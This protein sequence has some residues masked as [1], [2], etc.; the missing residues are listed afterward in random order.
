VAAAAPVRAAAPAARFDAPLAIAPL[1]TPLVVTGGFGEYRVGHFHAGFDFGT[2]KKV[3]KSV[4]APLP[5][6]VERVR[7]SGVGY[8]RSVYVRSTDGRLL[9]FGHLDAYA[10]PLAAWVDSIQRA[11]GQYEQDLWPPPGRFKVKVGQRIA[12]TGES[13]AGGP[14]M[15]F[16]IRRGDVA[17]HPERAG[18][19]VRDR[20][21]PSLASLTL[22]PLDPAS[23]VQ[24]SAAPFTRMLASRSSDTLRVL[25]R[26]R[27]VVGARDGVWSG[28]DRMVPWSTRIEWDDQWV[29][30]R[31]DSISWADEMNQSDY[32]YDAGRVVG[33]KGIVLWAPANWR[34]RFISSSAP[35]EQEAG[36]IVVREGD[37]PR[38]VRVIARD[39]T[40]NQVE[41][42]VVIVADRPLASLAVAPSGTVTALP[43]GFKR[44]QGKGG[45]IIEA[46]ESPGAGG[47][48]DAF[49]WDAP[50]TFD[51]APVWSRPFT[52]APASELIPV[53][54]LAW[55]GPATTP[56]VKS[57]AL[58]IWNA[59]VADTAHVGLYRRTSEDWD[60]VRMTRRADGR[61]WDAESSRLGDF[62]LFADTLAPRITPLIPPRKVV[63]G[64][65]PRWAF[66]A[67]IAESGSGLDARGSYFMVD[68]QRVPTEW[69]PEANA[70]RWRP[71]QRP[72]QGTHQVT[73]VVADRAGNSRV[74]SSTFVL[75]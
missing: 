29:E 48:T 15:H 10:P 38:T 1:D 22:E 66:E 56:L 57:F 32:V 21:P 17:F 26:V 70:L 54:S 14:H 30:C 19:K 60:F 53:R 24:G 33:D 41:R 64:A 20:Q 72:S 43:G 9:Q 4:R 34:P 5:G 65:Y 31:M 71:L 2:G 59:G 40:G 16:E 58:R 28:V 37:A 39:V 12:W 8:G 55:I 46:V 11:T 6:H 73:I 62:A 45:A 44:T 36:T 47:K 27:A 61:G 50:Q 51:R 23:S 18:L 75:D 35:R 25:G 3:G 74:R 52:L 67:T 63:T 13:G 7:A 42:A 69:D 49:E 68:G